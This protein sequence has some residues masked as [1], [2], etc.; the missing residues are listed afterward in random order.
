MAD[1]IGMGM[2]EEDGADSGER[3]ADVG[4]LGGE[5]RVACLA[6]EAG[7]DEHP[8]VG[9]LDEVGVDVVELKRERKSKQP[10]TWGTFARRGQHAV[11]IRADSWLSSA[12]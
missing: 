3:N 4:E 8:A 6:A 9:Q 12:W 2:G 11:T 10:D 5:F 1:V 7:V